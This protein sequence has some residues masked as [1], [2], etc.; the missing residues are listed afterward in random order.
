MIGMT[1]SMS[2]RHLE[3]E[4]TKSFIEGVSWPVDRASLVALSDLGLN[5]LQIARYFSVA[6]SEVIRLMKSAVAVQGTAAAD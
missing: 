1:F 5:P 2:H 6:P 3:S 4:L